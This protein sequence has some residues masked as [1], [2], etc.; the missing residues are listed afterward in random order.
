MT[1]AAAV[2]NAKATLRQLAQSNPDE[3][4][5]VVAAIQQGD[6]TDEKMPAPPAGPAAVSGFGA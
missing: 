3:F 1:K 5:E 2:A 6:A 4:R